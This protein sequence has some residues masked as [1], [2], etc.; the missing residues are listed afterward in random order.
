MMRK[1]EGAD[2]KKIE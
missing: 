1:K 2:R